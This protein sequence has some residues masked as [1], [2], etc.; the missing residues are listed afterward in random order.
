MKAPNFYANCECRGCQA[1]WP[2]DSKGHHYKMDDW[3]DNEFEAVLMVMAKMEGRARL[4]L[5]RKLDK[6]ACEIRPTHNGGESE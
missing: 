2:V 4:T 5:P 6:G 3:P 1:G